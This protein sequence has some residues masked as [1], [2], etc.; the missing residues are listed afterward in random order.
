[1]EKILTIYF[2]PYGTI[3]SMAQEAQRREVLEYSTIEGK[4]PFRL[5]LS[6]LDRTM[7]ARIDL[8]VRTQLA[9]GGG[10]TRR[11]GGDFFELKLNTGPGYRVYCGEV[12]EKIIII[13]CGGDKSTQSKDIRKAEDYWRDYK[14]RTS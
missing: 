5:W 11:L 12:G 9:L 1:M 14:Q 3:T 8:K 6:G 10:I 2:K 4:Y 13:L 7:Q